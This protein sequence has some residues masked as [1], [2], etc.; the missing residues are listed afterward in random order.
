MGRGRGE[1]TWTWGT[2]SS[3]WS[4]RRTVLKRFYRSAVSV[5][6]SNNG[7]VEN[8]APYRG[9]AFEIFEQTAMLSL[10]RLIDPVVGVPLSQL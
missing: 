4:G 3:G 9:L 2:K 5:Y 1:K 8:T 7:N 10:W 6:G